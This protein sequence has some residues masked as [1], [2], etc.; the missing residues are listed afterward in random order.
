MGTGVSMGAGV[1]MGAGR[2]KYG[3]DQ[4]LVRM[5]AGRSKDV[6]LYLLD[7]FKCTPL[8]F[9]KNRQ[10]YLGGVQS[11]APSKREEHHIT[12]KFEAL[13]LPLNEP[14]ELFFFLYDARMS[15]ILRYGFM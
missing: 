15:R 8:S 10:S 12:L 14:C 13:A 9:S 1:Q 3:G 11:P 4:A 6:S 7:S 2:G 5:G